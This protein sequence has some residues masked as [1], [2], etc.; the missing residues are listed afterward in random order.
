MLQIYNR[1]SEIIYVE[2]PVEYIDGKLILR[3][4]LEVGGDKL[5]DCAQGIGEIWGEEL[6][7]T[8]P[9]YV[10]DEVGIQEGDLVQV[11]NRDNEF[12]ITLGTT[13]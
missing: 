9:D 12:H 6:F 11:D 1:M 13:S 2:G 7:V 4:P 3:I 8:I 10:A 5:I